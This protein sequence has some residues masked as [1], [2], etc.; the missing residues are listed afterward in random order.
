MYLALKDI[1]SQLYILFLNDL[2]YSGVLLPKQN[3]KKERERERQIKAETENL[4][5]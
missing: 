4:D 1:T 5:L 3:K 2:Q